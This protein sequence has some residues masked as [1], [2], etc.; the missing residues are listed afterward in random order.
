MSPLLS[1][2]QD[3]L[4]KFMVTRIPFNEFIGLKMVRIAPGELVADLPFAAHLVG[5]VDAN[6]LH[7]GPISTLLD[8]LCGTAALSLMAVPRR[9]AT[10]DL[11]V[12]FLRRAGAG[13]GVRCETQ[14]IGLGEH[15]T[16]IRA[17]A[18]DG[19]PGHPV[20]I[21]TATFALFSPSV[22]PPAGAAP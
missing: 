8:T 16:T 13:L 5:D 7:E 17:I 19:D 14:V 6:S 10:L 11:R 18:H 15:L 20:A 1:Y 12:D 4:Q 22:S 2:S 21:A 9:T 3:E